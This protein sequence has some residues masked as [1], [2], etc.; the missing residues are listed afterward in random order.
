MKFWIQSR[1]FGG[2]G[3]I[4]HRNNI[5]ILLMALQKSLIFKNGILLLNTIAN[6][7]NG[8]VFFFRIF[9]A[10]KF[11]FRRI[12]WENLKNLLNKFKRFF[13]PKLHRIAG[14]SHVVDN[15]I[16]KYLVVIQ[17]LF[18]WFYSLDRFPKLLYLFFYEECFS[19]VEEI[20]RLAN[21]FLVLLGESINGTRS[22]RFNREALLFL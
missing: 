10:A 9:K 7:T 6:T 14:I 18:K 16:Q 17:L 20:F 21:A 1:I 4:S 19:L 5:S 22:Q 8:F 11:M 3:D 12:I 15:H 13:Q 2:V